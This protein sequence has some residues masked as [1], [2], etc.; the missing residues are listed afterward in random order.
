MKSMS[1]IGF[2]LVL[3]S[4]TLAVSEAQAAWTAPPACAHLVPPS[5]PAPALDCSTGSALTNWHSGV[6]QGASAVDRLWR[7]DTVNQDR[8]NWLAFENAVTVN[9]PNA[10]ALISPPPPATLSPL[11]QC[12]I[13]G[14]LDAAP[15]EMLRYHP[16]LPC[17]LDGYDW[18]YV[19]GAIYCDFAMTYGPGM[20]DPFIS[21]PPDICSTNY[22][23][24]CKMSYAYISGNAPLPTAP[25]A[26]MTAWPYILPAVSACQP[27]TVDSGFGSY[28]AVFAASRDFDC[29]YALE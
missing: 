29:T 21:A 8:A 5:G 4:A 20:P 26:P 28:A 14:L 9:L 6:T 2:A 16:A 1:K 15:C 12:R 7:S 19:S 10:V 22:E 18:G 17:A 23:P 24:L 11:L 27:F 13:Q 3:A 25:P